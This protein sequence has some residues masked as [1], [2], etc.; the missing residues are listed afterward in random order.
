MISNT[1]QALRACEDEIAKEA[2]AAQAIMSKA[3]EE[4]RSRTEDENA[5]IAKHYK[6]LETL[7]ANKRE[8]EDQLA[9]EERIEK[10]VGDL[11]PSRRGEFKDFARDVQVVTPSPEQIKSLG[12][13]FIE[14][15]GYKQLIEKGLSGQEWSTG[16]IELQTK[17]TLVTTPGTALTPQQYV[18]GIVE[19][20]FERLT[21]ADLL[22]TVNISSNQVTYVEETT[23]TNAADAVAELGTKPESTLVFGEANEPIRKIATVLPVSDE[24]LEDAPQI[25]AYIN[26]RLVLFVKQEEEQQLLTGNGTSPNLRGFIGT[27][28][29]IGTYTRGSVDDNVEALFKA[30]NGTR[31]SSYLDP[32]AIVVHP[33]DWQNIRLLQDSNGQFYGGGPFS[34]GP[35]GGPQGPA[36]PFGGDFLWGK[37]VVVT[38][39]ITVGT[40]L[41]GAF[42]QAAALYRRSGVT[43]EA[44]NS[45]STWFANNITALR[46]E[47]RLGLAVYRPSAFTAVRFANS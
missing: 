2:K 43:V 46:A 22:P 33:T 16:P 15:K 10:A 8:L 3:T 38:S 14:A 26:S 35:Y 44:T 5:E 21:V 23:A 29:A 24:M 30:I 31:G 47:E 19:T 32:D 27:T 9:T 42:G 40:A 37:R 39:A 20:L 1:K 28:R 45:H 36:N 13:Q 6:T 11:D 7:Q 34:I 17:G 25:R 41:L 12:D 18:P 4:K